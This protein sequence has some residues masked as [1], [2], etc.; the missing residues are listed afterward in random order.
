MLQAALNGSRTRGEHPALPV[1]P[2]Q[3]AHAAQRAVAAGADEIHLHVRRSDGSE[4]LAP[5]DVA[6]T[7]TL[8]RAA[9][10]GVRVGMSTSAGIVS[11]P[12][13]RYRLVQQWTVL[14]DYVSVNIHEAGAIDL[15]HLLLRQGVGVEAGVWTAAAA[16]HLHASGVVPQCLRVLIEAHE[17]DYQA[18]RVNADAIEA[19]LDRV[20]IHRPRLLHGVDAGAWNMVADAI[21]RGYHTRVGLEDM[22]VLPDGSLADDNA[23][24]VAVAVQLIAAHDAQWAQVPPV[25]GS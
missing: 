11:D 24:L 17:N 15:I 6:Q 2:E 4:S 20:S 16:E 5:H 14:P 9:C 25:V 22:L 13:R 1:T 23:A 10:A 8:V 7:L 21:R 18:A 3:I 12:D 19:V